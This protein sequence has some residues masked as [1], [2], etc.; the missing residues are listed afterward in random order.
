MKKPLIRFMFAMALV[1]SYAAQLAASCSATRNTADFSLD[2][3]SSNV[4]NLQTEIQAAGDL[5]GI[6]AWCYP[7]CTPVSLTLGNQTAVKSTVSGVNDQG[8]GQGFIYY[9]LSTASAGSQAITFTVSGS[10]SGIQLSYIDF[11]PSAGCTFS[12]NI[13][14]VL[15]R[16]TD[17]SG[18]TDQG[19]ITAP[20]ITPS[21]GDLLFGFTYTSQHIDAINSP[22]S[23]PIYSETQTC[24]F[25]ETINAAA[26]ILSAASGTTAN[27]MT[28][29]HAS[30]TWQALIS[31]FSMSS[32]SGS[33]NP[34]SRPLPPTNLTGT[35]N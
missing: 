25:T 12:H 21:A 30:N 14:S 24:E 27:N 13:D 18:S 1:L 28:D 11:T 32:N 3:G 23:C 33:S 19:S 26:Y 31:S 7:G 22:W 5:V 29:N 20:S 4:A 35:V 10:H 9:V 8:T 15:G 6:T 16:K 34:V 2:N 17:E